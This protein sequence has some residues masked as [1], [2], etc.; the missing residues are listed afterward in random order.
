MTRQRRTTDYSG[1]FKFCDITP[2]QQKLNECSADRTLFYDGMS[3]TFGRARR[4]VIKGAGPI[5][6]K[7]GAAFFIS[8]S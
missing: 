4:I 2:E 5:T 8:S 1:A 3:A 7:T 6:V